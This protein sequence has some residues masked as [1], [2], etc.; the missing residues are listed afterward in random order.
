MKRTITLIM[1]LAVALLAGLWLGGRSRTP[2]A[3]EVAQS[4]INLEFSR[5]L[6]PYRI[7]FRVLLGAVLVLTLSGLGWGIV[8]L[9]HRR[10]DTVYADR[11]GLYPIR[12]ARV[13]RARIYH[14]PNRAPSGTT[15]YAPRLPRLHVE[16][17]LPEG[18]ALMQQQVTTQAQATQAFRA[19]VSSGGAIPLGSAG[20]VPPQLPF[21]PLADRRVSRPIPEVQVLDLEPS[22]IERLLIEDGGDA[23]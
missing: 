23:A 5:A 22:H 6:F 3:H 20:P 2:D 12:E 7:A 19:A 15:V 18:G 21:D 8:R 14:D 13:G 17:V 9:V 11:A 10:V 1:L 16:H 4:S